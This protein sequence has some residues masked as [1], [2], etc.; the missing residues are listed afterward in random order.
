MSG[1]RTPSE[2]EVMEPTFWKNPKPFDAPAFAP[3]ELAV[4]D[5]S[6]VVTGRFLATP[7]PR[8]V[9]TEAAVREE[10]A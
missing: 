8:R 1:E 7:E 3:P 6:A 5:D 2:P 10:A 9:G 4:L